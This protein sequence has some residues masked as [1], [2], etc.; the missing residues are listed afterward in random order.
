MLTNAYSLVEGLLDYCGIESDGFRENGKLLLTIDSEQVVFVV[1]EDSQ[2]HLSAVLD[3]MPE[4]EDLYLRLLTE[5]FKNVIDPGY[6]HYAVE[7]ESR[8]L[9]IS[10][11]VNTA[12]VDQAKFIDYFKLFLDQV[13]RWT[14]ALYLQDVD[15][16]TWEGQD[17]APGQ[18]DTAE[19]DGSS[20]DPFTRV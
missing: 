2:I 3:E 6:Y 9:I 7:P 19:E 15:F 12:Q 11:S 18:P 5:N 17:S 13:D 20:G 16:A 4:R 8:S 1:V 14:R 10:L